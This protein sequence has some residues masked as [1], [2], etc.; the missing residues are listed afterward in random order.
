MSAKEGPEVAHMAAPSPLAGP[1]S[2]ST[3]RRDNA[4]ANG[5][6]APRAILDGEVE[7]EQ[8]AKP[9]V[10]RHGGQPLVQEELQAVVVGADEEPTPLQVRAPVPDGLHQPDE[11][12]LVGR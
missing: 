5:I 11:L 10:L 3:S 7:P 12:A 6:K 9:L 1:E 4:S 8:L 2:S